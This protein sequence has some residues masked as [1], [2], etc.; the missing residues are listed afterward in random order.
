MIS[1]D[2]ACQYRKNL[3][4]RIES[5]ENEMQ[6]PSSITEIETVIPMF[7]IPA[8]G[9]SCQ[10]RYSLTFRPQMGRTDGENIER[11]WAAFNPASMQ[12]REM[13]SGS[14]R[15]VLNFHFD[16]W[17]FQ[18][19]VNMGMTAFL[20]E[21]IAKVGTG[22]VFRNRLKE[23]KREWERLSTSH[24]KFS[25]GFSEEVLEE[26]QLK[27]HQWNL[28]PDKSQDP[29][30]DG[31]LSEFHTLFMNSDTI[32]TFDIAIRCKIRKSEDLVPEKIRSEKLR[33]YEHAD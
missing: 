2:I 23:A 16:V 9:S 25:E 21:I 8:H 22:T 13:G 4:K 10:T 18:R 27:I 14:R 28:D 15:D 17:N 24:E 12:V 7:H 5:Y 33:N 30:A 6:L 19:I 3:A 31:R 11:G 20:L 26:I 29:Y 1:Y 32:L